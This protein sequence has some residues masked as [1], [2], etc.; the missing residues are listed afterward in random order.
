MRKKILVVEKS[1]AIR[2]IAESLLHQNGFD[3][4]SAVDA[5]KAKE[6]IVASEPNM[7]I[8]GADIKEKSG[9]Y[10]YEQLE[11]NP[12]TARLPL[13]LISSPDNDSIPYPP[14]VILPRPFDPDDFIERVK[15]FVGAGDIKREDK[16][17]TNEPFAE[18]SVDDEFLDSALGIDR[19]EVEDSEEM[20]KTH[21]SQKIR[22]IIAEKK[23]DIFDI[24][25]DTANGVNKNELD[26]T[27]GKVESLMIRDNSDIQSKNE[28]DAIEDDS[29]S[30]SGIDISSDQYGLMEPEED[31]NSADLS[32]EKI[33]AEKDK[34][35]DYDWFIDEMKKET[36][37]GSGKVSKIDAND[38]GIIHTT[39]AS[40]VIEP[41]KNAS[42]SGDFQPGTGVADEPEI[43]TGGVDQFISEFKKEVEQLKSKSDKTTTPSKGSS[44]SAS[45]AVMQETVP[46]QDIR[47][48]PAEV[49]HYVS[50]MVEM[51]AE[52]V[53]KNIV[54]KIDK[55]ELYRMLKD[56]LG[57][58]VTD[59]K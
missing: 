20:D 56:N 10:L 6:L 40:D 23:K 59:K 4:L 41:I 53:A 13:L 43:K 36:G 25:Q 2:G 55:D 19:I 48:D 12:Q 26:D 5:A 24:H 15:L 44:V 42:S 16:I 34:D 21:I 49:H 58:I 52:K 45:T 1:D 27:G 28:K 37:G 7:I 14:E 9:N 47:L 30:T 29:T 46:E 38:S 17:K 54:D 11:S 50:H 32:V 8:I 51:L 33:P 35:H 31:N 18:S 39:L 3:V 57:H 22:Q